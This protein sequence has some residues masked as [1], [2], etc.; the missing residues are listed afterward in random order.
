MNFS[1]PFIRRPIGLLLSIGLALVGAVAYFF[2][3]VASLPTVDLPT[4]SVSVQLPGA[5]PSVMASTVTAPL[6][7]RI[8]EIAGVTELSSVSSLGAALISVQF[9]LSRS[10]DGA[11]RDVQAAINAAAADLPSDLPNSPTFHKVIPAAS[12]ILI[13]ALTSDTLAPSAIYDAADTI[14]VQR[15]SQV[16]GVAQVNVSGADQ[17][18]IRVDANQAQLASMGLSLD[19]LRSTIVN[20]N[21]LGPVGSMDGAATSAS[22]GTNQQLH[23]IDDYRNLVVKN[24]DGNAVLLSSVATVENGPRNTLSAAWY[25]GKPAVILM[26]TKAGGCECDRH[27]RSHSFAAAADRTPDSGRRQSVDPERPD[28]DDPRKHSA[29]GG[30]S[31]DL[32]GAR[33]AGRLRLFETDNGH[34]R[35]GNYRTA[36]AARH[37]CADV[38]RRFFSR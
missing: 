27:R 4:I 2:L 36:R 32:G 18:A 14:V 20:A 24:A 21:S 22:L 9:D 38:V 31:G 28:D 11:A 7:R 5:E 3:P 12:P 17:P 29:H 6:E 34:N 19:A 30:D 1:E 10:I 37:L 35:R 16:N 8:G 15:L 23:D 25:N 13:L 33:H 26:I